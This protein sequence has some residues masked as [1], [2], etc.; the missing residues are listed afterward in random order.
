MR[1]LQSNYLNDGR[2]Y[3]DGRAATLI[4]IQEMSDYD[5]LLDN[6]ISSGYYNEEYFQ[7]NLNHNN[8]HLKYENLSLAE[9]LHVLNPGPLLELGCGRG[10]ILYLLQLAGHENIMGLDISQDA[11]QSAP[12]S[13][14][15]K[16]LVGGVLE[17][18]RELTAQGKRFDAIAGFDIWEHLHPAQLSEHMA[19]LQEIATDDAVMFFILPA[20]GEDRIFGEKHPLEFEENRPAFD[21]RRPFDYLMAESLDPPIPNL[22]HLIWAH[23]QWWEEQFKAHGFIRADE[24]E[25]GLHQLFDPYLFRAQQSFFVLSRDTEAASK[26]IARLSNLHT[27]LLYL[28]RTK[29]H[30][31]RVLQ[32]HSAETG[33]ELI[34]TAKLDA[35]LDDVGVRMHDSHMAHISDLWGKIAFLEHENRRLEDS[36]NA[37]TKVILPLA[38]LRKVISVCMPDSLKRRLKG[39]QQP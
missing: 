25:K 35:G 15:G 31:Y 20:F 8:G 30:F 28:W 4:E 16:I 3:N 5:T 21:A 26:R 22:G 32:K 2:L 23:S 11:V 13:L 38:G 1:I 27:H 10:D 36:I 37:I 29:L 39:N 9:I 19:M 12:A 33:V 6:I 7:R 34:E 17:R 18:C 14:Q 24:L